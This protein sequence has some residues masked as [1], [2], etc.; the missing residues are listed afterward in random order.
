MRKWLEAPDASFA[1]NSS[2]SKVLKSVLDIEGVRAKAIMTAAGTPAKA[3]SAILRVESTRKARRTRISLQDT[4]H[5]QRK[6]PATTRPSAIEVRRKRRPLKF[7]MH[8][9]GSRSN[10]SKLIQLRKPIQWYQSGGTCAQGHRKNTQPW[11]TRCS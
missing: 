11:S 2:Q 6:G 1:E 5:A 8:C 7:P 10:S 9:S 4:K 3:A